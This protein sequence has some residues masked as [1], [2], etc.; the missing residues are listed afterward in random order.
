[1]SSWIHTRNRPKYDNIKALARELQVDTR[2]IYA[3]MG[4]G[5]APSPIRERAIQ[6]IVD[7]LETLPDRRLDDAQRLV[8]AFAATFA[9]E[10]E[11]STAPTSEGSRVGA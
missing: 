6:Q 1:V 10:E 2:L 9:D 3:A 4:M 8:E 7:V 11:E 5:R